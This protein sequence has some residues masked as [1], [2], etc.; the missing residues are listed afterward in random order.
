MFKSIIDVSS[1]DT[2]ALGHV[3]NT[4]IPL[5][6]ETSRNPLYKIFNPTMELNPKTWN[7]I[8]VHTEFDYLDQIFFG[9]TIEIRTYVEKI[10]NTSVTVYQEAWQDD[11][12]TAKGKA[13]LVQFDFNKQE[14]VLIPENIRKELEKH[15]FVE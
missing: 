3:N 4:S 11:N 6:F 12:L 8:M 14:K 7:L 10:G 2:D 5:W 1:R 9:K 15:L 13:I